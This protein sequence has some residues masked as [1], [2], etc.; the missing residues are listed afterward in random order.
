MKTYSALVKKSDEG[1]ISDIVLI[2]D[3]FSFFAFL[4]TAFWFLYHKMR[5]EFIILI[6][7]GVLLSLF[8]GTNGILLQVAFSFVIAINANYWFCEYL[9]KEGYE[10]IGIFF[11]VNKEEALLKAVDEIKHEVLDDS[12]LKS[13]I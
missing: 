4:F 5:K 13:Q 11:G 1:K 12:I 3:G 7:F 9:T 2:K 6:I 10:F 8:E